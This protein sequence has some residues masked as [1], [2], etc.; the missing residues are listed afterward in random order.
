LTSLYPRACLK[1][2]IV[3]GNLGLIVGVRLAIAVSAVQLFPRGAFADPSYTWETKNHGGTGNWTDSAHWSPNGVPGE[4]SPSNTFVSISAPDSGFEASEITLSGSVSVNSIAIG[5]RTSPLPISIVGENSLS[6]PDGG[7][8]GFLGSEENPVPT[9][10]NAGILSLTGQ[11]HS[12]YG[13]SAS[14]RLEG[15]GRIEMF[16]PNEHI[17]G[18]FTNA[19]VIE[20]EGIVAGVLCNQNTIRATAGYTLQVRSVTDNHGGVLTTDG[21]SVGPWVSTLAVGMDIDGGTINANGG[22]VRF[23]NWLATHKDV[24]LTG[25]QMVLEYQGMKLSGTVTI[26]PDTTLTF[27]TADIPYG[28]SSSSTLTLLDGSVLVNNGVLSV[29]ASNWPATVYVPTAD[30]GTVAA[31]L[32]GSGKLTLAGSAN[33]LEV[34]LNATLTQAAGHTIEGAGTIRGHTVVNHGIIIARDG[35]LRVG[36]YVQNSGMLTA[37][38]NGVLELGGTVIRSAGGLLSPGGGKIKLLSPRVVN[39]EWDAG[40]IEVAYAGNLVPSVQLVGTN[41]FPSGAIVDFNSSGGIAVLPGN[42]TLINEGTMRMNGYA[43]IISGTSGGTQTTALL[44]GGGTIELVPQTS[45]MPAFAGYADSCFIND[46]DHTIRG[47]GEFKAAM[48]NRGMIIAENGY[49]TLSYPLTGRGTLLVNGTGKLLFTTGSLQARHLFMAAGSVFDVGYS[50]P[51]IELSRD[52]AFAQTDEASWVHMP[53]FRMDGRPD[54]RPQAFEVGGENK[55]LSWD[56]LFNPNFQVR[57]LTIRGASTWVSLVDRID[58][59]NRTASPE[60]LYVN[61]LE[62][63][64]G[65]TLNLNGLALYTIHSNDLHRVIAG[66]GAL[67]G[68]G[69][70]IDTA[71]PSESP[72]SIDQVSIVHGGIDA[73]FGFGLSWLSQLGASYALERSVDLR[74]WS[75]AVENIPATPP[76]NKIAVTS[77]NETQA[78]FYRIAVQ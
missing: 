12:E 26:T 16:G 73:P 31:T 38:T 19:L 2:Y 72:L 21:Y 37:G 44:T 25:G 47:A 52:L 17:K 60:A 8:L 20:G 9:L 51:L 76:M 23:N 57:T 24:T 61:T 15:S 6:I 64:P 13:V 36:A 33:T 71:A 55:G 18:G 34:G 53:T 68:G 63:E 27:S 35:T 46:T 29:A 39:G 74:T 11:I 65:G 58:N 42:D 43:Q 69:A 30:S 67:F 45:R 59:G 1:G 28:W 56:G 41:H 77:S 40:L 78:V 10:N 48:E 7:A 32:D 22:L 14:T 62:V 66:E 3:N 50:N 5:M 4:V 49:V 75:V 54:F 70:I